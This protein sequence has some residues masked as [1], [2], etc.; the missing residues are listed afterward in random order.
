MTS[1]APAP[2]NSAFACPSCG[3]AQH[4]LNAKCIRC[5]LALHVA[6]VHPVGESALT[7]TGPALSKSAWRALG[8]GFCIALGISALPFTAILFHPLV[9]IIHELGHAITAWSF[10]YPALPAF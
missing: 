4:R 9:T 3:M 1:T 8:I 10:G 6:A 5:G 2:A 7:V